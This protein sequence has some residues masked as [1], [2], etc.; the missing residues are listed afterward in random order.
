MFTYFIGLS[1]YV[2]I[3]LNVKKIDMYKFKLKLI[4]Y[5]SVCLPI[6]F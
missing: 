3:F 4:S 6:N 2:L 1:L 5:I